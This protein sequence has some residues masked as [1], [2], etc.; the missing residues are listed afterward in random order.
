LSIADWQRFGKS[1]GP[2][3]NQKMLDMENPDLIL[4]FH[5]DFTRSLGTRDMLHKAIKANI[6]YKIFP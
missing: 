4:V 5:E 6:P 3:R 2:R 1:A